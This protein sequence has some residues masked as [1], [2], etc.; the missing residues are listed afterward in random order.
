MRA[1]SSLGVHCYEDPPS[2][3]IVGRAFS[4]PQT[5]Q[6][7]KSLSAVGWY[8]QVLS[9]QKTAN[10]GTASTV[11]PPVFLAHF[12]VSRQVQ[13]VLDKNYVSGLAS[14]VVPSQTSWLWQFS[15]ILCSLSFNILMDRMIDRVLAVLSTVPEKQGVWKAVMYQ[16]RGTE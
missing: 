15:G 4:F 14:D 7:T 5:F 1:A 13:S 11:W 16:V 10:R 6:Q 9:R 12:Y 8:R 2:R 3:Y